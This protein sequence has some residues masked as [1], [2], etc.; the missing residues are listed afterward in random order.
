MKTK[1]FFF[2]IFFALQFIGLGGF[3]GKI[4]YDGFQNLQKA[5]VGGNL[6]KDTMV[7]LAVLFFIGVVGFLVSNKLVD[8][9]NQAENALET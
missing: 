3:L 9:L 1:K 8:Q 6:S 4:A 7:M 5:E 2:H